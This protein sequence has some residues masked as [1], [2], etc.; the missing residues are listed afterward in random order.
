[1]TPR[2]TSHVRHRIKYLDMGV[3]ESQAFVFGGK[4]GSSLRAHTLREFMRQLDSESPATIE[5]YL[6]RHDFSRWLLDVFRDGP[7]SAHVRRLERR[8]GI[9]DPRE[10]A[11]D[12]AQS[13]RARYD[14]AD[15]RTLQ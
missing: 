4:N 15:E 2:L 1:M 7:L 8:A 10:L 12:I 14:I 13:I 5:G 6:Q 3:P 9:D 11:A